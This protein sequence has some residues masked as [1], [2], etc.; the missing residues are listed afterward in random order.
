MPDSDQRT[1]PLTGSTGT[2]RDEKDKRGRVMA[3]YGSDGWGFEPYRA[4]AVRS[5][6]VLVV[7]HG[8]VVGMAGCSHPDLGGEPA[9]FDG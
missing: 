2:R 9:V 3:D 6:A 4:G 7:P 8:A 1:G 5:Q